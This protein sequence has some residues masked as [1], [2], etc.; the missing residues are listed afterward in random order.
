MLTVFIGWKKGDHVSAKEAQ[1][2]QVDWWPKEKSGK[3][4]DS[5]GTG[6]VEL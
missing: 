1:A 6:A 2:H 5:G 3:P 4:L